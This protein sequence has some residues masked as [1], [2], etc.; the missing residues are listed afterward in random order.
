[1]TPEP[2]TG[3]T[4]GDRYELVSVIG[5]GGMA[6]VWEAQ[7]TRLGR[8]VAIKILRPDLAR[9]PAFQ[10][11]FRREA[12][13]AASLNHPNIVAAYDTGEDIFIDGTE[14]TVVPYI[15]MEYVDGMTLRQILSSGRRL[16]PERS[17]EIAAGT[18][19]ALDY[20]HRH[21]IVHRDIKPA[22]VML[23]RTGDVK[24][25][26]FGIARALNDSGNTM[27]SAQT[28]MGTAQY[29]SPEQ[30]RGEVVDA[31]SDLYSAGV[32]L[33]ELLTGQP[34]FTGDSPV[35]IAYQHVSEQATPPSQLDPTLPRDV[36]AVV[37]RSLAKSPDE[38][39]QTAADFRADVE[40][41]VMGAPVTAA[42]TA[43][44]P[45]IV[46]DPTQQLAPVGA[47]AT[48]AYAIDTE[49]AHGRRAQRGAGFIAA[50]TIG[51]LAIIGI[52]I[53]A[54]ALVL[55]RTTA[56]TV[57]VPDL[58]G[59]TI[60]Q[61]TS[62]LDRA[63]LVLGSQT[64]EVSERPVDTI[65]GQQPIAGE[66]LEGGQAVNVT[67]SAGKEK[68]IVPPL[69]GLTSVADAE[70]ALTD[71]KLVLGEVTEQDAL[72]P[73]GYVLSQDPIEGSSLDV[74]AV[75]NIVVSS[76]R[77]VVP[78][79]VGQPEENA[80]AAL[81][82]AGFDVNVVYQESST[83]PQGVVLE[84]DP[85]AGSPAEKG[86]VVTLIV[87]INPTPTPTP[88]PTPEPT[89]TPTPEPTPTPTPTPEPTP[90]PDPTVTPS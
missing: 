47:A 54:G 41:A 86:T 10:A 57:S 14:S 77:Q 3:R 72:E 4:L 88:T 37:M 52:A 29:L 36:D 28:V 85:A 84:Q 83:V 27:T 55:N 39:Y 49:P 82:S 16:L 34:P 51:V 24:V 1:M 25:M 11:R 75:V 38:R 81:S 59:L 15:V 6:E 2:G 63:G 89:P 8:R 71:A 13:S 26:D 45:A 18:L 66:Q 50:V 40:R 22:N 65:I 43:A 87:A 20:A 7:D 42:L 80:R 5:R 12:Q 48:A 69:I 35:S 17:L 62:V 70:T 73:A 60:K 67:V 61:A 76:G 58:N 30:A 21:G 46:T 68:T 33:Y 31:R 9:D 32:V 44:V 19:S 74:G 79:V 64:P 90:E 78:S 23:T 56:N 53:L